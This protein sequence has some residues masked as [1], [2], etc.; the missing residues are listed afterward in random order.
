LPLTE[1]V[2]FKTRIQKGGRL[3]I[4]KH[5]RW[6]FKL[7]S[8]QQLAVWIN[9]PS[10]WGATDTFL[11]RMTKDGRIVIPKL[12]MACLKKD[13]PN[14]EGYIVDVTLEPF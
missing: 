8:N 4:N 9:V 7:E 6:R 1:K 2:K 10:I 13:K 11:C 5:V 3:Q 12:I 14:L